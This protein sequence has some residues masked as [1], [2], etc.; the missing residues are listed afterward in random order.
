MKDLVKFE[1][2][3]KGI[4]TVVIDGNP[5]WVAKDIAEVLGYKDTVN[6][7]KQ[8]CRG[9][10]KRHPIVD[11]L[12]RTQ[13]ARVIGEPDL[14]R[15]IAHSN[16]PAAVEFEKWIFEEV[17]PQI[18]KTGK[19][20]ARPQAPTLPT[21]PGEIVSREFEALHRMASIF[22]FEGNQALLCADKAVRK[23][24]G[25]SPVALLEVDL[26]AP[27]NEALII[28]TEIGKRFDPPKSAKFINLALADLGFQKRVERKTNKFEWRLTEKGKGY[29]M[30]VDV[31]KSHSDG[32]PIQQIKWKESVI[33][34]IAKLMGYH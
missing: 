29:G 19:Y 16:L 7:V 1:F 4:R 24:H 17:L 6:A 21:L 8:H 20:E 31:G 27:D 25:I 33:S 10:V 30:Y 12:G 9:V 11:A 5:Y 28:A 3:G 26:K 13:E 23:L 15:L 34:M 22:G 18:R 14:Y 2:Q 32:T